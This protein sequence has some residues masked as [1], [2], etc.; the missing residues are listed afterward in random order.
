MKC[1]YDNRTRSVYHIYTLSQ[2][3]HYSDLTSHQRNLYGTHS[4]IYLYYS[5]TQVECRI[6]DR[7]SDTAWSTEVDRSDSWELTL[8]SLLSPV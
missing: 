4:L 1:L 6:N 7:N 5:A 2:S 8:T 3:V